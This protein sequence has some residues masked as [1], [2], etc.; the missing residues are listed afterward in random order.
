MIKPSHFLILITLL[1]NTGYVFAQAPWY[2]GGN[3]HKSS[4]VAWKNAS[5]E[6]KLAT[7][8]DWAIVSPRI[9]NIIEKSGTMDTNK[10]FARELVTCI[11]TATAAEDL[12]GETVDIALS[13]MALMGWL[14]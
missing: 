1:L 7:S 6:N 12:S 3:L 4:I 11:D 8:A 5:Y 10:T 14:E 13:C 2:E 9:K